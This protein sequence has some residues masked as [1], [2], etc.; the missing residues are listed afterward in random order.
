MEAILPIVPQLA[1]EYFSEIQ[2]YFRL[3]RRVT[4]VNVLKAFDQDAKDIYMS[5][6]MPFP[7]SPRDFVLRT[8]KIST[9]KQLMFIGY[10]AS[11]QH[12]TVPCPRGVVR[13]SYE[14]KCEI[15]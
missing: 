9:E 2:H 15:L 14:C 8:R 1:F 6:S 12:S 10:S 4:C 13:G 5:L 3:D 11:K 7:M